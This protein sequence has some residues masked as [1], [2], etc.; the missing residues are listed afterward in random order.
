M[1]Q[2]TVILDLCQRKTRAFSN[3]SGLKSIF[4]KLHFRDVLLWTLGVIV[5]IKLR[6]QISPVLYGWSLK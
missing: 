5:E 4:E 3:S 6:F 2:S 1:Q